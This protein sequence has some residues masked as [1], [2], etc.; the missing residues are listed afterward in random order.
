[1]KIHV[2]PHNQSL[3]ATNR[4]GDRNSKHPTPSS[5]P[6]NRDSSLPVRVR[7]ND[8]RALNEDALD[9]ARQAGGGGEGA[10]DGEEQADEG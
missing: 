1:M 7:S 10:A 6:Q 4:A 2:S 9:D 5:D 3:F 8:P